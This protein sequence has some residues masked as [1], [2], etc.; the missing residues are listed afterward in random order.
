V[1][2]HVCKLRQKLEPTP[3]RPIHFHTVHGLGYKFIP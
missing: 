1:D 3:R 2:N